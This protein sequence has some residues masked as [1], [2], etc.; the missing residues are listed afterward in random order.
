[1]GLLSVMRLDLSLIVYTSTLAIVSGAQVGKATT[2]RVRNG[3]MGSTFVGSNI[4][5]L[6]S[7]VLPLFAPPANL[8]TLGAVINS[9]VMRRLELEGTYTAD[10]P[11]QLPSLFIL[12]MRPGASMVALSD[13]FPGPALVMASESYSAVLGGLFDCSTAKNVTSKEFTGISSDGKGFVIKGATVAGCGFGSGYMTANIRVRGHGSEVASCEISGGA[14]GIWTETITS[15]AVHDN[16]VHHTAVGIDVDGTSG[17][18][19]AVYNNLVEHSGGYGLWFEE[20]S[21]GVSAFNN[22]MR[23]N[24][25]GIYFY[26]GGVKDRTLS[27]MLIVNNIVAESRNSPLGF[28]SHHGQAALTQQNLFA[29]NIFKDNNGAVFDQGGAT[30]FWFMSNVFDQPS[31]GRIAGNRA[32]DISILDPTSDAESKRAIVV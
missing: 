30:D 21:E 28:G 3:F 16:H 13:A 5:A 18:H 22:T 24:T 17:P 31:Y 29:S 26:N 15:S 2:I 12:D 20:G 9:S 14:R 32:S 25:V 7:T 23:N 10:V 27:Q 19:L 11:M 8:S 4:S 6:I 1:M